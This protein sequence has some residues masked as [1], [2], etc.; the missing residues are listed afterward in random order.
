MA[1][2]GCALN[3]SA[4][5][6]CCFSHAL[7]RPIHVGNADVQQLA[8]ASADFLLAHP[9]TGRNFTTRY[10]ARKPENFVRVQKKNHKKH[11]EGHRKEYFRRREGA[12]GARK[13]SSVC[14]GVGLRWDPRVLSMALLLMELMASSPFTQVRVSR[15]Y[16]M[17]LEP[18]HC[19]TLVVGDVERFVTQLRTQ[20]RLEF[21]GHLQMTAEGLPLHCNQLGMLE[22]RRLWAECSARVRS[23]I[24]L[25]QE[26]DAVLPWSKKRETISRYRY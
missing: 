2:C 25:H 17:V 13:T 5:V 8:Q 26:G 11:T 16:A 21:H 18:P 24:V 3:S 6:R 23:V 20:E 15:H 22:S 9:K 7:V 10:L 12:R 14:E 4:L 19:V 1:V